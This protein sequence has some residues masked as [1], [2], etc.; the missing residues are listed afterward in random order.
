MIRQCAVRGTFYPQECNEIEAMIAAF[1]AALDHH[2]EGSAMLNR[3]PRA[4]IVPHAGYVYSGFTANIAY[5]LLQNSR[6]KRVVVIGPSHYVG[7]E[8]ISA[9]AADAFETPCGMLAYDRDYLQQLR[10]KFAIGYVPQAHE[11]EH[12]TETQMPFIYHYL[13]QSRVIEFIYGHEGYAS[14]AA[15]FHEILGDRDNVVV[16]ST[17]LSHFYTQ[18]EALKLDN[19]C[20][21]A[22]ENRDNTL[23]EQGC[24][25]CG[26][27]GVKAMLEV[28]KERDYYVKLLDYRTS[29]DAGGDT[30][31]VVG[32]VSAA[33]FE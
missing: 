22:I 26:I 32:Y 15:L 4:V 29:A 13:P 6:A 8:G 19:I 12:S 31:R 9:I 1:N 5:R 10:E 24:E 30:S 18:N 2:R 20:L 17:D 14:L 23:I 3:I 7:I 16:V 33:F 11:K 25:A 28:A 27:I 21:N